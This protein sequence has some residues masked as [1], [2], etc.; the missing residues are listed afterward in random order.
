MWL[1]TQRREWQGYMVPL[2]HVSCS[3]DPLAQAW[4]WLLYVLDDWCT[5]TVTVLL[6]FAHETSALLLADTFYERMMSSALHIGTK[7]DHNANGFNTLDLYRNLFAR[8]QKLTHCLSQSSVERA[9]SATVTGKLGRVMGSEELDIYNC[10]GT[11]GDSLR[12]SGCATTGRG[13]PSTDCFSNN[14]IW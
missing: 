14:C 10:P 1:N 13:H 12:V 7:C 4:C 2:N 8:R 3:D 5:A 9:T 11:R 6:A